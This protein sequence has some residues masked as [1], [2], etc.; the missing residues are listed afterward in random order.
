M[1]TSVD[2]YEIYDY[3]Y[4]PFYT[5]SYFIAAISIGIIIISIGIYFYFKKRKHSI[6]AWDWA[7]TELNKINFDYCK[8]KNDYKKMYFSLTQTLKKYFNLRYQWQT[9]DKTDDELLLLLQAHAFESALLEQLKKIFTDALWIKFANEDAL[10]S[11]ACDDVKIIR[12]I[13]Q[14]TIPEE[15]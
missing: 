14:K 7:I 9:E 1:Q 6:T 13:I 3:A 8:T 10:K 12:N 5:S 15:K 11:Q 4:P 2:F